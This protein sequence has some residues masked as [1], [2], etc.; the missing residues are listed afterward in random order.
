MNPFRLLVRAATRYREF[1]LDE[2]LVRILR[3]LRLVPKYHV[4]D[5]FIKEL[6][7]EGPFLKN[8]LDPIPD[9]NFQELR[10]EATEMLPFEEGLPDREERQ[11]RFN[12]GSRFFAVSKSGRVLAVVWTNSSFADLAHIKKPKLA[13]PP[14]MIYTHGTVV[15]PAYQ[16]RGIGKWMKIHLLRRLREEGFHLSFLA[17][18]L[19]DIRVSRWHLSYGCKKW[20]RAFHF[21][22]MGKDFWWFRLT[23]TGRKYPEIFDCLHRA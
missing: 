14:G 22:L 5:F 18:L 15:S 19:K 16:N 20:G 10:P 11:K 9:L 17:V 23:Q 2:T 21:K 4:L 8:I 7:E 6:L 12:Q 13:V 1:G 3:R